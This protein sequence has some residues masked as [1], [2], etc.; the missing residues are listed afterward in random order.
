MFFKSA[1]KSS[2]RGGS[3]DPGAQ[4]RKQIP[5]GPGH[6]LNLLR[7]VNSL[8]VVIH[9]RGNPVRICYLE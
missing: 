8:R 2:T 5:K 4:W 9:Y 6:T 7:V 1:T 3:T